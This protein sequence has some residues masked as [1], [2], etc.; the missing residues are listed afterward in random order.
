[1]SDIK[2]NNQNERML[3]MS[4]VEKFATPG[5]HSSLA[6]GRADYFV[7][8]MRARENSKNVSVDDPD[9]SL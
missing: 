3:W 2:F 5:E 9:L 4:I 1:M 7:K 8:E 6:A